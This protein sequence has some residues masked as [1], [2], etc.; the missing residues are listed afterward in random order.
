MSQT[1]I[2]ACKILLQC[3]SFPKPCRPSACFRYCRI[4]SL[5]S[6]PQTGSISKVWVQVLLADPS[7]EQRRSP[8][9]AQVFSI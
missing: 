3:M 6:V 7:Q 5:D 8:F 4:C 2:H 1:V 9:H